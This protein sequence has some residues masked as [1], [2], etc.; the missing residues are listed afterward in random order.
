MRKLLLLSVFLLSIVLVAYYLGAFNTSS[1]QR[2]DSRNYVE[3]NN[4]A[5]PSYYQNSSVRV[6]DSLQNLR[7]NL[8]HSQ[9]EFTATW[10]DELKRVEVKIAS[11]LK[12]NAAIF[13]KWQTSIK[14]AN[15]P[16]GSLNITKE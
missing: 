3:I 13:R 10:N 15:L 1:Y 7:T 12:E 11:P 8:P 6:D 9:K 14:A 5:E 4:I 2:G 16:S